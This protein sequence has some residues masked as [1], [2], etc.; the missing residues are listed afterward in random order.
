MQLV[1]NLLQ[2]A[3]LADRRLE[4]TSLAL[5]SAALVASISYLVTGILGLAFCFAVLAIVIWLEVIRGVGLSR[6]KR[7]DLVWP[8][9]FDAL[10]TGSQAGLSTAEQID[11]LATE[12]PEQLR[13]E[14]EILGA[15]LDLGIDTDAALSHWRARIGSRSGDYLSIVMSLSEEIGGRGEAANWEQAARELRR[16]QAVVTQVRAKQGWV[17]A[18]AKIAL[19]APWLICVL[20]LNLEQN[21]SAF[22]SPEGSVVLIFGLGL[23]LFAYFLT[24]A[25]G[26]LRL[27]ERVFNV[28]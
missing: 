13:R 15:D 11:Y 20:L 18:S 22:A 27:P 25:L 3:G 16:E 2:A 7:L 24:G 10:R 4:V 17:L 5:G 19:L 9:V 12:G 1:S 14:F 8:S 21:R 26:K 6:Q 23:S 28:G